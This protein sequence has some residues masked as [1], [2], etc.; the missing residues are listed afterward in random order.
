MTQDEL[1]SMLFDDLSI[2]LR[3]IE[4]GS[5]EGRGHGCLLADSKALL[6]QMSLLENNPAIFSAG[7]SG[8]QA[9]R[10]KAVREGEDAAD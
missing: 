5:F 6:S 3:S 7:S 8:R 9:G 10:C 2:S 1:R 4:Y